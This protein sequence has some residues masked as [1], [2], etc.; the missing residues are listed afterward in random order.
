MAFPIEFKG[1]NLRLNAPIGSEHVVN[2]GVPAFN[3]GTTTITCW[4]LSADEMRAIL[5]TGTIWIS[6]MCGPTQPPLFVG[7]E[8]TVRDVNADFGLPPKQ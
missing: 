4:Q 7:S 6:V 2:S 3:N 1:V 8:Q 5:A